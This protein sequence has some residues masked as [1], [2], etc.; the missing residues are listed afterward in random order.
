[1][2]FAKLKEQF[3]EEFTDEQRTKFLMMVGVAAMRGLGWN[4]DGLV[5]KYASPDIFDV[6]SLRRIALMLGHIT[7]LVKGDNQR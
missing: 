5:P 2:Q 1:M 4:M 6:P 3:V 7:N